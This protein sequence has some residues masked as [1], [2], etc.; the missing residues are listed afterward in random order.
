MALIT[1]YFGLLENYKSKYGNKTFLLMQVGS[2]YE[3]YS[4]TSTDENMVM[5]SQICDLKIAHKTDDACMAGFRDYMLDK[6][7]SKINESSYT[8]I[9]FDQEEING[10]IERKEVA[11]YS[12]GT[13]FI[14][15]EKTLS[16]NITCIWINK[17][18]KDIIFGISNLDIFTGKINICE[19]QE[20]YYHNPTTY[21]N[22][23]KFISIYNPIE[24]I[25]IY[26]VEEDIITNIIQYIHFNSKKITKISINNTTE[27]SKQAL[28][29]ENQNYQNEIIKKFYPNLHQTCIIDHLFEKIISFQSLCF[30]LNYVSQ[31]NPSLT[32][33]LSEPN[34]ENNETLILANHSLKQLNIIDGEYSGDYSSVLKLINTCKT[35]IGQREIEHLLLNPIT[36]I[37]ELNKS[38]N[39]IE[40]SLDHNYSWNE[41]LKYIKDIEKIMR[42]IIL[43]RATPCD[44]YDIYNS[45]EILKEIIYA[46][47]KDL[48]ITNYIQSEKAL[49]E[50]EIIKTFMD[51]CF[52]I[53]TIKNV[54]TLQF[55][56]C[57]DIID[58][59]FK[60]NYNLELDN[61]L[62]LKL[63]S[64]DKLNAII[65]YLN[66]TYNLIDKKTV[67]AV[68]IHETSSFINLHITKKRRDALNK[69]IL[70][71]PNKLI[72]IS[73]KSSYTN[74]SDTF[75]FDL[76]QVCY[77]DYNTSTC[78]I[79]GS[80]IKDFANTL[81]NMSQAFY[82]KLDVVYKTIFPIFKRFSLNAI[83]YSIKQL[84]TLN[85]KCEIASLYN[86][87][88]PTICVND[89]SYLKIKKL[90]HALIEHIEKNEL[91]VTN[92]V[93]LGLKQQ[94]ILLFGTNA[95]GKTSLIKSIGICVI[96]AQ[97]GFYVPCESM[98]YSP[99]DYI[100]TRI[101]GN[102]NIF[103]GLSTFGVEMS[104]L[105]VILN[106]ANHKSLVLGDELCSGT[107]I[108]SALSIFTAGL[109]T[110]YSKKSSFIFAT[111]F[112]E[113][114]YFD[115][116]T[117]M[118]N[119]RLMHLKVKYNHL[120]EQLIYDRKLYDGAGES[121]YGLEVCKS[122]K[123]PDEFLK[124][125]YEIR[126]KYDT[127]NT[128]ILTLK[129]T[130]YNKD[131]LRGI[132]EF[133]KKEM[134]T[135]M[136]HMQYQQNSNKREYI[137]EF[138]KDHPANLASVCETC[139]RNIHS[140]GLVY[141]KK[142][143]FDGYIIMIKQN[144]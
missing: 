136:H 100:F 105:R 47:Q 58:T 133:C 51:D 18:K 118:T 26:N 119:I 79:E 38:Y 55:D 53:E 40:H 57:I 28:N 76:S 141:E 96:L 56:K 94:G 87:S 142:K 72:T 4:K 10:T 30:L 61:A 52:N 134:G 103:K 85:T 24:I 78:I 8:S 115:E 6:Y 139:H 84:D 138:H 12:P 130:K 116:I 82:S 81:N 43:C 97:A 59:L 80:Q 65:K 70:T 33:L 74:K 71:I 104:E 16:N 13:M 86:Y 125:A 5:F 2:F 98:E 126:N 21:D 32:T 62:Q 41:S 124:R 45:C 143:T 107:E 66:D 92:D 63:E 48:I 120:L 128:N 3:V 22:I 29:C 35:K 31:H 7:L 114:Q 90:R 44:F 91:Y 69:R 11:I 137:E 46:Y 131:K 95:V 54:N 73:F 117:K 122:L 68:K 88:K 109:E 14:D 25:L 123:M 67:D 23:E 113:I 19:Y 64:F 144:L 111:H 42:K 36:N 112:H 127:N 39:L 121:M 108:D 75:V 89:A 9:I 17:T 99:Y 15:D 77:I 135:E 140:L 1:H 49:H 106:Q 129:H 27:L 34:I 83:I 20:V 60:T 37:E 50:I 101:I 102:D 93:E 132:C 110:L